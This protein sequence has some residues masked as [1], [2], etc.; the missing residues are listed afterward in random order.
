MNIKI[1]FG[2]L[3][4]AT[5]FTVS[6]KDENSEK[7]DSTSEL[8]S[9]STIENINPDETHEQI[10]YEEFYAHYAG[11]IG[12][13]SAEA[14]VFSR[15]SNIVLVYYSDGNGAQ[16]TLTGKIERNGNL[17]LKTMESTEKTGENLSGT[18]TGKKIN[19][20][21]RKQGKDTPV[22]LSE[23]YSESVSFKV[24]HFEKTEE[25]KETS[26][27]NTASFYLPNRQEIA[28]SICKYFFDSVKSCADSPEEM[29]KADHSSFYAMYQESVAAED[30]GNNW[31]RNKSS[32][33]VFNDNNLLCYA[34]HWDE[35]SG[36]AHG[37]YASNFFTFDL[38]TNKLLKIKD[39]LNNPEDAYWS[40]R[41]LEG[42]KAEKGITDEELEGE[43][44][45]PVLPS[46]NFYLSRNG[47]GFYFNAYEIASYAFGASDVYIEFTPEVKS[48][49]K[50]EILNHLK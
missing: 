47:I 2:T 16:I 11:T 39:I 36:G 27:S 33:V 40:K 4:V 18:F 20:T 7:K 30:F 38:K 9:D 26:Y 13:V 43:I 35:Y 8:K 22:E 34:I 21:I 42:I 3:I 10:N 15:D 6:C 19:G 49:I 14:D 37:N 12:G 25:G 17:A 50:P 32:D 24:Y 46:D 44:T 48:K 31:E 29:L 28:D 41:I 1:I 5:L 23:D 45:E